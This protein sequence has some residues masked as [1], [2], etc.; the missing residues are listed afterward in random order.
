MQK[1]ATIKD[2]AHEL[3][4]SVSTVSRGLSDHPDISI[5][6]RELIKEKAKA[7]NYHP[8][9]LASGL[10]KR[11]SSTIGL[12]I[13][14]IT[15][16]FFPSVIKGIESVAREQ[17]YQLLVL[18]SNDDLQQEKDNLRLCVDH[19]VEGLLVSLSNQSSNLQHFDE[20]RDLGIPVVLFDK[21]IDS[22]P[23]D[24]VVIDDELVAYRAAEFLIR[25]GCKNIVAIMGSAS[26]SISQKRSRGY[27]QCLQ[28]Y[29]IA[30]KENSILFAVNFEEGKACIEELLESYPDTDGIF[31][32]SDEL[33]AASS[34]L[35]Q[36]KYGKHPDAC[37]VVAI[38]DGLMPQIIDFPV[39]YFHHNGFELG[40]LAATNLF[41]R[42]KEGASEP[43]NPV[44]SLLEVQLIAAGGDNLFYHYPTTQSLAAIC[45]SMDDIQS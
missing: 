14:E 25:K 40:Q 1:R 13:P 12:I 10:R 30:L 21:S 11:K 45:G 19:S 36:K 6:M 32:M 20:V 18:Q 8:N 37:T 35:L 33:I 16:F 4:V 3:N 28:H 29:G 26:L 9:H 5:E 15:M 2:I 7:L 31:L 24:E 27:K 41:R 44:K 43:Q 38:S 23:F 39:N 22:S 17:G 42:I 34:L